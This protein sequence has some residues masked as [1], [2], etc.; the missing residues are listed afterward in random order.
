[1]INHFSN[2]HNFYSDSNKNILRKYIKN[3]FKNFKYFSIKY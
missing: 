3:I 1:M 2:K